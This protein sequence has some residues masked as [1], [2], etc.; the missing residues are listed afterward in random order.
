MQIHSH[1]SADSH[2]RSHC[3]STVAGAVR[4]R[5]GLLPGWATLRRRLAD[6][7]PQ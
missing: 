4:L 6:I 7:F 5:Y 2:R 1:Q 3:P